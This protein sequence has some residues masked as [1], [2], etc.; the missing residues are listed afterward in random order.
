MSLKKYQLLFWT[1]V[2]ISAL[3]AASPVL[4]KVLVSPR[5][6]FFTEFWILGPQHKAENYPFN[7]A[8][9]QNNS[10]FLGIGNRLGYSA[11][12]LIE[13]KFRNQT[14]SAP[15]T[16]NRTPSSLPSLFNITAFAVDEATWEFPLT[17][18]F[19]Y[20]YNETLSQVEFNT[21][22]L[23]G[24]TIDVSAHRMAQNPETLTFQGNLFFELWLY[25]TTSQTFQY[26]ER[27]IGLWLNATGY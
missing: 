25:D 10:V 3:F 1:I 23:N 2:G 6:Q 26:H 9:N 18:S 16:F 14:Q 5:T 27:F 17:F 20:K 4:S 13:V 7:I 15:D 24:I 8:S 11:Y 22:A 19:D 12:Y 21:L